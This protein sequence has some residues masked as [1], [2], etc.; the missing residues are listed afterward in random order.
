[1]VSEIK[2]TKHMSHPG[3]KFFNILN[4]CSHQAKRKLLEAMGM[5]ITLT[6]VIVSWEKACVKNYQFMYVCIFAC[7]K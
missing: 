7:H 1:M 6:L 4:A 5:F 3:L 2:T